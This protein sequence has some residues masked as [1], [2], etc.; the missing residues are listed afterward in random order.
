QISTNFLSE[1]PAPGS[2]VRIL[3]D[4]T[5]ETVVDGLMLPNGIDFD[6]EGNLYVVAGA[7][8]FGAPAGMVLRFDGVAVPTDATP[9]A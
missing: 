7:V 6:A 3:A 2:V 4:G 8:G 1:P 5:Q 9:T